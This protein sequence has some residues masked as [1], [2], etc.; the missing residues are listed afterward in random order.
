MFATILLA[1]LAV[2]AVGVFFLST[3][4]DKT[5]DYGIPPAVIANLVGCAIVGVFLGVLAATSTTIVDN[6][7]V[8]FAK[9]LGVVQP[10]QTYGQGFHLKAPWQVIQQEDVSMQSMDFDGNSVLT[11]LTSDPVV[12]TIDLE[13][14]FQPVSQNVPLFKSKYGLTAKYSD[15]I[16]SVV[17]DAS[18]DVAAGTTW[19]SASVTDRKGF[20]QKL[21]EAIRTKTVQYFRENGFGAQSDNMIRYGS[22]MLRD[23]SPPQEVKNENN[24]LAAAQIVNLKQDVM[25]Q[26]V[27]KQGRIRQAEN[28]NNRLLVKLP[29]GMTAEQYAKVLHATTEQMNADTFRDMIENDK[30][31]H[32]TVV[33]GLNTD[34]VVSK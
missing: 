20:E 15:V 12:L 27:E 14:N 19:R 9:I 2:I 7:H 5:S 28:E 18:R 25:A 3:R 6:Q 24:S 10:N 22:D 31:Q 11:P 30:G 26:V 23:V 29:A 1:L 34:P 33:V 21:R 16:Y 4:L 32:A 8:G 13:V 17:H